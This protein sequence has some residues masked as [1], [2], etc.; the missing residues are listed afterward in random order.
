M[1]FPRFRLWMLFPIAVF[2]FVV[3]STD[4]R[5]DEY[6]KILATWHNGRET[7][8]M[9]VGEYYYSF[10]EY[11]SMNQHVGAPLLWVYADTEEGTE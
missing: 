6:A 3:L 9:R 10:G 2:S 8:S 11:D 7:E 5:P 4:G 1:R